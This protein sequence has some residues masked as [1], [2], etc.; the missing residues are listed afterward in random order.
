MRQ[1]IESLFAWINRLTNIENA[2]L[3]RSTAGLFVHIFG[4]IAAAM[5][6]KLIPQFRL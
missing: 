3:V 6:V 5:L 1:P 4:K 2:G